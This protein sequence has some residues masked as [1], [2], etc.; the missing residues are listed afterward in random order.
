[1]TT[2]KNLDYDLMGTCGYCGRGFTAN[3]GNRLAKH[4]FQ[5]PQGWGQHVG[6]CPGSRMVCLEKS[7]AT[8]ELLR[9]HLQRDIT[10]LPGVARNMLTNVLIPE[11]EKQHASKPSLG[12]VPTITIGEAESLYNC[13]KPDYET[14]LRNGRE[15]YHWPGREAGDVARRIGNML[16]HVS[17]AKKDLIRVEAAIASWTESKMTKR[18]KQTETEYCSGSGKAP[19]Q[20]KFAMHPRATC[21]GCGGRH[22]KTR[23][24]AIRKHKDPNK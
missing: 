11:V 7:T 12:D 3:D 14:V 9:S 20:D 16:R 1:M 21:Q 5:R 13:R 24:F 17:Y 18:P 2:T 10:N 23:H 6:E 22:R 15:C 4:G 8:L 19:V